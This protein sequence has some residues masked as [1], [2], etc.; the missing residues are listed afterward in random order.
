MT[1][2]F[3]VFQNMVIPDVLHHEMGRIRGSTEIR[4]GSPLD[5]FALVEKVIIG[6]EDIRK[7]LFY[8]LP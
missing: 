3:V 8:L 4:V 5:L 2:W 6:C 7:E 1:G